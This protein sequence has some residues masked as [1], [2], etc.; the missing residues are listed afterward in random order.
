METFAVGDVHGCIA[1]LCMLLATLK[2]EENRFIFLGDYIDRGPSS[3]E[4]IE[5]LIKLA[6]NANHVF[7][8]GNH[9]EWILR[10]RT[11]KRWF[12]T[13]VADGVGGKDTLRSYGATSFDILALSH[14]PEAHFRFLEST[15]LYFQ[16]DKDIFVHASISWM[17]PENTDAQQLLWRSFGDILPHPSGKR[18]ICG[19]TSQPNGLPHDKGYAVCVDTF[20]YQTG[21][22]TALNVDTNEVMQA[23][24]HGQTRRFLLGDFP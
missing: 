19:H 9:D 8:R 3:R 5:E 4:V 18:V 11:E 16:T 1:A 14:V 7:L 2:P 15:R 13:W 6:A 21:W 17:E 23:N 22:L 12:K 24:N 20:C 10:A